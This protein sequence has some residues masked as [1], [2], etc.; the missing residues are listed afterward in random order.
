MNKLRANDF[1]VNREFTRLIAISISESEDLLALGYQHEH[2]R[3]VLLRLCRPLLRRGA[4]LAY[5]G[6]LK[7]DNSFT[8]D[9]IELISN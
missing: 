6:H 5:G 4:D 2:L 3:D 9:L 7:V 1:G 8:R